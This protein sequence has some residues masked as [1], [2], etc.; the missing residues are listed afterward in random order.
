MDELLPSP[1][2]APGLL[3]IKVFTEPAVGERSPLPKVSMS[4]D[5]LFSPTLTGKGL[6]FEFYEITPWTL[7]SETYLNSGVL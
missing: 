5:F 2:S 6:A 3:S 4:D 7:D 1:G